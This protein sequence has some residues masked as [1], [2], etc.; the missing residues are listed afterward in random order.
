MNRLKQFAKR[1]SV[2]VEFALVI[3]IFMLLLAWILEFG[4]VLMVQQVITNAAREGARAGSVYLNNTQALSSAS[5]VSGAF[6]ESSCVDPLLATVSPSFLE[7]GGTPALQVI[8]SYTYDSLLDSFIAGS[9]PTLTLTSTAIM[10]RE[11]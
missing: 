4:R 9:A 6:L 1:G 5:V 11:T 10:R 7:T 2:I 3:P 8:V